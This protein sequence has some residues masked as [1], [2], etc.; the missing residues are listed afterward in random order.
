MLRL[1]KG[2]AVVAQVCNLSTAT[3]FEEAAKG[4]SFVAFVFFVVNKKL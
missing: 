2:L 3:P 4:F 1:W